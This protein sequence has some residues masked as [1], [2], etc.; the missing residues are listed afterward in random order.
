MSNPYVKYQRQIDYCKTLPS[1][2][3]FVAHKPEFSR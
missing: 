3:V 2:T 1:P